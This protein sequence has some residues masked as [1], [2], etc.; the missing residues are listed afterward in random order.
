MKE[1]HENIDNPLKYYHFGG[2]EVAEEAWVGSPICQQ[3]MKDMGFTK[4][5]E[6]KKYFFDMVLNITE[7][8]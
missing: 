1:Y 8:A 6:L 2:D 4:T 3:F 5:T 7:G